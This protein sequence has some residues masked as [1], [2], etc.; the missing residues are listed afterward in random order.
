MFDFGKRTSIDKQPLMLYNGETSRANSAYEWD[1]DFRTTSLVHRLEM[2]NDYAFPDLQ[3]A[4][5][6]KLQIPFVDSG[7]MSPFS[8]STVARPSVLCRFPSY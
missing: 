1:S 7:C 4:I 3:K 6:E 2:E 8:V 5:C